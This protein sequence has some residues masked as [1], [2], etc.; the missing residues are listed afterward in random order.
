MCLAAKKIARVTRNRIVPAVR[1]TPFIFHFSN[2]E[3]TPRVNSG[4]TGMTSAA[5]GTQMIR[6]AII[7]R[8]VRS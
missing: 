5:I 4:R 2:Q 3:A 8:P 7:A 6:S 1:N